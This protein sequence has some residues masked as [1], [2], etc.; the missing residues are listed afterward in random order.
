MGGAFFFFLLEPMVI[1]PVTF[2]S[3]TLACVAGGSPP[4]SSPAVSLLSPA[5]LTASTPRLKAASLSTSERISASVSAIS[6]SRNSCSINC[7]SVRTVALPC[8]CCIHTA[9][10][11]TARS[12]SSSAQPS[13]DSS[14]SK[15]RPASRKPPMNVRRICSCATMS[16]VLSACETKGITSRMMKKKMSATTN[17]AKQLIASL[18]EKKMYTPPSISRRADST[19][20]NMKQLGL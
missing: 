16:S 2:M 18:L 12:K 6:A 4:P 5:S 19:S 14:S 8:L 15:G 17:E 13:S 11:T 3:I 7:S 9:T 20:S 10:M 1:F